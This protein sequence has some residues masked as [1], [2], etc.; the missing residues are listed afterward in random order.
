MGGATCDFAEGEGQRKSSTRLGKQGGIVAQVKSSHLEWCATSVLSAS[1]S[2]QRL[3][4]FS[5]PHIH[6]HVLEKLSTVVV[7]QKSEVRRILPLT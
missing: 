2:K 5:L 7:D 6:R 3:V 4:L 1:R